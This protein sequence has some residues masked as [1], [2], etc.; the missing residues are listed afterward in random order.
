MTIHR[1]SNRTWT[2]RVEYNGKSY[3]KRFK[4]RD[5]AENAE[6]N[7]RRE[8]SS[9]YENDRKIT[10]REASE[11]FLEKH[12]RLH[13]A[14]YSEDRKKIELLNGIFGDKRLVDFSPI[15]I[16]NLRNYLPGIGKGMKTIKSS[17]TV[18]KYHALVKAIFNKMYMWRM[19]AGY[20]PAKGVRLKREFKP[21]VRWLS[22]EEIG[23]L[24]EALPESIYPY[25][26]CALHTGMRKSEIH[27]LK[28]N[29]VTLS[30]R[31]IYIVKTKS[32]KPRHI[33][34][35]D[36]LYR[37]LVNLYGNG[38]KPDEPV[39]GSI[40]CDYL[41]HGFKR[42]CNKADVKNF[43]FHDLRHTFASYL[44]MS[45]VNIFQVSK[46]LGHSS[47]TI[48]EKYYAHFAPDCKREEIE[49]LN[50]LNEWTAKP[51][52]NRQTFGIPAENRETEVSK[53]LEN[54]VIS[55]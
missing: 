36:T 46:W 19:F 2:Y 5:K 31:D 3:R 37:F 27:G 11:M 14:S 28:W 41:S 13:K 20:N 15:D 32:S 4:S 26:L 55:T 7:L 52:N 48:T 21:H 45:G 39:F 42:A 9:G 35:N 6:A 54:S 17:A 29:D 24:E 47:V 16:E 53:Q 30:I 18:D 23:R 1:T 8:L 40:S 50:K 38:K 34:V 33:P 22:R 25:Y 43:R 51:S 12:S 10:F 44:V 49:K